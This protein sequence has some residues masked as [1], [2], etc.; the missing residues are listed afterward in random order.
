MIDG[1]RF[2]H[3]LPMRVLSPPAGHVRPELHQALTKTLVIA[4]HTTLCLADSSCDA[5]GD[6]D[7]DAD[8]QLGDNSTAAVSSSSWALCSTDQGTAASL[9]PRGLLTAGSV[10]G[11][12]CAQLH[13]VKQQEAPLPL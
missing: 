13:A 6:A 2:R 12:L 10:L 9:T 1:Q 3:S 11:T 4:P 7:G 8:T 5:D